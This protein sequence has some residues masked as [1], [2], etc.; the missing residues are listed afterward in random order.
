MLL[1]QVNIYTSQKRSSLPQIDASVQAIHTMSVA[2]WVEQYPDFE[3]RTDR[4]VQELMS[5]FTVNRRGTET[6]VPV[7][8]FIVKPYVATVRKRAH[9][10]WEQ[11]P[12]RSSA[13]NWRLAEEHLAAESRTLANYLS[14]CPDRHSGYMALLQKEMDEGLSP[15]SVRVLVPGRR[16]CRRKME[17][18]KMRWQSGYCKDNS[19]IQSVPCES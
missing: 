2:W 18:K 12:S 16:W 11:D 13:E 3:F 6:I 1:Y 8:S 9:A 10:L 17:S 14:R 4:T 5:S 15:H 19:L 7:S